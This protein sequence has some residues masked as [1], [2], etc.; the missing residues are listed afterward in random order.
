[1]ASTIQLQRTINLAQQFVRLSPLTFASN[2]ANDPAFS[3]ADWVKQFILAPPFAWRWNRSSGTPTA[4]D[5]VTVIGKSDYTVNIPNFGWLEKGVAYDPNNGLNPIELQVGLNLAMDTLPNQPTRISAQS[6]DG[7]GNITFRIFP[8]PD[9]VYNVV[10]IRQNAASQFA[11][12]T[13]TWAPIPDYLSYLYNEGFIAKAFE[14]LGDPRFQT[15][16]QLFFSDLAANAEGLEQSQKNLWLQ[17]RLNSMRQT[18]A[19]QAGRA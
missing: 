11:S 1:M 14:Y 19:A 17:D 5:F 8:N 4:P 13:Q 10:V 18:A 15:A 6:D 16:A 9:A 7:N 12:P 3:N 2:T